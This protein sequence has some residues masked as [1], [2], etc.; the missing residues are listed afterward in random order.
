MVLH[1]ARRQRFWRGVVELGEQVLGHLA[2]GVDEHVQPAAVGHADHDFLH[3]AGTGALHQLVHRGDEAL[4]AFEREA[5]LA[6]VLGVQVA[7][8]ALGRGQAVEDVDLLFCGE[9]GLGPDALEPLLPPALLGRL[10]DVHVLGADAAAV[11]FTQ[12]LQDFAQRLL[13]GGGEVGVRGT[14]RDVHVGLAQVVERR[15]QFGNLGALLALERIEVGPTRS[16][17]AIRRDQG[18]HVHL[19]ARHCEFGRTGLDSEGVRLGALCERLDHRSVGDITRIAAVGGGHVLEGVEV[20]TPVV[21]HGARVVEVRLV[22]LLDVGGIAPEQVRRSTCAAASSSLTSR[23]GF[24][25]CS[26]LKNLPRHG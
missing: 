10:G 1:V 4:A 5:L 19:L 13:L 8:Q 18:L 22:H 25:R 3:A 20:G 6:H 14:E 23:T 26:G 21:G 15:L 17:R 12:R 9:A 2:Q 16:Q 24:R 11:G 7:L